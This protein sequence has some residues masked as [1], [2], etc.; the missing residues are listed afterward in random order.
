MGRLGTYDQAQVIVNNQTALGL[1]AVDI[2]DAKKWSATER[3]TK[4]ALDACVIN[5]QLTSSIDKSKQIYNDI[6]AWFGGVPFLGGKV[7]QDSASIWG[8]VGLIEQT[9]ALGTLLSSWVSVDYKN[10]S[11]NALYISQ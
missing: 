9:H 1:K 3:I 8:T 5:S 10:V 11:Q 7:T 2:N 4:A 6:V